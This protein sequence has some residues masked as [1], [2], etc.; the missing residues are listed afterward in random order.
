MSSAVQAESSLAVLGTRLCPWLQEPLA[1]FEKARRMGR[2]GHAWLIKG[3]AGIGKVN[4]AYVLAQRILELGD[5]GKLPAALGPTDAV[6]AMRAYRT[7]ADHHPDLHRVFPE[8]EKR[9]IG[10][11]QIRALSE[12][13]AMKAFRGNAKVAVI[14]PAEAMT[15]SAANA[16]L[17][18]LEEPA[19]AT[20]LFLV[21]HQPEKLLPT[22]R[23][24]CQS[25]A[26]PAPDPSMIVEWLGLE[27]ADHPV[28]FLSGRSPLRAAELSQDEKLS[29]I[30]KLEEQF[31]GVYRSSTDPRE[32]AEQ[33]ARQ[34]TQ[35]ALEW[36]IGRL[37]MAVRAQAAQRGDSKGVTPK[38]GD[39]FH[40]LPF[41]LPLRTLFERREAAQRLLDRL[42]SGI[43]VELA[44]HALLLGF[45]AER[46]RS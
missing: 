23:S 2:L 3:P 9:T 28:L 35:L 7:P 26:V 17:K 16:L 25:L 42:G 20:Y 39:S 29:F 12:A 1:R 31:Q 15:A 14:E 21:S 10:I 32:V 43:N 18:T 37:E 30:Q 34:D 8:A 41:A 44:L 45:R 6:A 27:R 40:N 19:E 33:W 13:L 46:G 4:L 36:L 22:I 24:R 11:E 38:R 5:S